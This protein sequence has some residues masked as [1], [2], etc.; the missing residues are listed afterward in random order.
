M[1]MKQSII[2]WLLRLPLL[3]TYKLSSLT[4]RTEREVAWTLIELQ[5]FGWVESVRPV[6]LE[7]DD[8]MLY[9]VSAAGA[10][11]L[12]E[13]SQQ[14]DLTDTFPIG[15]KDVLRRLSSLEITVNVN[16]FLADLEDAVWRD[17]ALE[18][19]DL[20]GLPANAQVEKRWWPPGVEAYGCVRHKDGN[21]APFFVVL[22]RV[23]APRFHRQRRVAAWYDF[24]GAN[25]TWGHDRIP[26]ILI[27]CSREV[28]QWTEAVLA[29]AD[30][31]QWP[32]LQVAVALMEDI[33]RHDPREAIW[34][35]P[36]SSTP[37]PLSDALL[38]WRN[39]PDE[40]CPP[41]VA[42]PSERL[43]S[44]PKA[45]Q[46]LWGW[47]SQVV[48]EAGEPSGRV[49]V[50]DQL[51]AIALLSSADEK[52]AIDWLGHH[53]LLSTAELAAVLQLTNEQGAARLIESLRRYGLVE[54]AQRLDSNSHHYLTEL[55]LKLLAAKALVPH[56]RLALHGS[57]IARLEGDRRLGRLRP[58]LR[59]FEH[60]VGINRF[61]VRLIADAKHKGQQV[62]CWL[63]EPEAR[64][65]FGKANAST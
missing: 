62:L 36:S 58:M 38:W 18:L 28:E 13:A 49:R 29:S 47:A 14:P 1:N 44:L 33:N 46:S 10:A 63:N 21:L 2:H 65:W 52:R 12:V 25:Q 32:P 48:S 56:R 22:D 7:L 57:V 40:V 42:L 59:Q 54:S 30:R 24:W 9:V 4:G 15:T 35:G 51:A 3:G 17:F 26:T 64:I 39:I 41:P 16:R 37:L 34:W 50:A 20:R 6:S 5:K 23:E 60:T 31:R 27:L 19:T 53:P 11:R 8:D 43:E 45:R 55:G 61:F